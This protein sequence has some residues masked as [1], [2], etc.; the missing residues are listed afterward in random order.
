MGTFRSTIGEGEA[1][2]AYCEHCGEHFE[3]HE[4]DEA[5]YRMCPK[6]VS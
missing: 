6:E 1:R 2:S 3:N 4:P 5:G